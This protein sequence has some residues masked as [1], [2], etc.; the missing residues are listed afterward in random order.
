MPFKPWYVRVPFF[1][2][3]PLTHIPVPPLAEPVHGGYYC[4]KNCLGLKFLQA[5]DDDLF[6]FGRTGVGHGAASCDMVTFG[7]SWTLRAFRHEPCSSVRVS[8]YIVPTYSKTS[9]ELIFDASRALES[10]QLGGDLV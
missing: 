3:S 10:D 1:Y 6:H 8:P 9:N 7:C 4:V 2:S 5:S